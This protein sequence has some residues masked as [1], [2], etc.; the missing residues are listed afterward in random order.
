MFPRIHR[1]EFLRRCLSP[2][3]QLFLWQT[4][5]F[6]I[7]FFEKQEESKMTSF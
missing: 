3:K 5:V 7:V 4:L 1:Y 6:Y 2:E